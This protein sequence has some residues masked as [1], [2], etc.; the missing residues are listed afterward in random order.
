VKLKVCRDKVRSRR[1][2][3]WLVRSGEDDKRLCT[4]VSTETVRSEVG[5]GETGFVEVVAVSVG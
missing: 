5:R 2:S 1:K 4:S 3:E